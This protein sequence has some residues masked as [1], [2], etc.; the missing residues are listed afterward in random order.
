[1]GGALQPDQPSLVILDLDSPVSVSQALSHI[2]STSG[3]LKVV[4]HR[5]PAA[6][7]G[8]GEPSA[9]TDLVFRTRPDLCV[10]VF[11]APLVGR[12]GPIFRRLKSALGAAPTIAVTDAC[13]PEAMLKLLTLG[14]ADFITLP[15][16]PSDIY[17]RIWRFLESAR[18]EPTTRSLKETLGLKQLVG[19]STSF[20]EQIKKI[21]VVAKTDA[22]VLIL[23]ETGTGKEL[24][25]RAVHYLSQRA[26]LPFVPVNCG[27]IPQDL[28]ENELFGHEAGA[29][30]GASGAKAGLIREAQGG[31]LFLD[32]I[33]CLPLQTQA[34]LLRFLQEREYRPLGSSK[35][36]SADVRVLAAS[37]SDLN[38]RVRAG[39]LRQD[40]FYRL[41]VI[42]VVLPALRDRP[43]D[44]VLLANHFAAKYADA[45]GKPVP[46]FSLDAQQLLLCYQWPG[47]VRELEHTIER[48]VIFGGDTIRGCDLSLPR[49]RADGRQES[50]QQM[51]ARAVA[52][53]EK[54]C[55]QALLLAHEGNI[56]RA[57]KAAQKNRRAFFELIRKHRIDARRLRSDH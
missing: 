20:L 6:D 22:T 50:F 15:L 2:L 10:L 3:R 56:T 51:K 27:A 53:F 38:E 19:H 23:G 42:P 31:T 21:S 54:A 43:Q 36:V 46:S 17:P 9:F 1:M 37:N 4:H 57:A 49:E 24:C 14:V 41:N 35:T 25:A 26:G 18:E 16:N 32:E 30:T 13:E 34:K 11:C 5:E 55:I 45:F 7:G 12:V 29:F 44:I 39:K 8:D 48:A 52:Q 28:V 47:N 33:D 40:L